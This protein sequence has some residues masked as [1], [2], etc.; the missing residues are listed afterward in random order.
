MDA[1][2]AV[3]VSN[4]GERLALQVESPVAPFRA[5][6]T[7]PQAQASSIRRFLKTIF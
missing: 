3:R 7:R 1:A 4:P 5:D 2:A 6:A